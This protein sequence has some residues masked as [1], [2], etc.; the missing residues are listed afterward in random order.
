MSKRKY[1]NCMYF[2]FDPHTILSICDGFRNNI[3]VQLISQHPFGVTDIYSRTPLIRRLVIRTGFALRVNLSITLK[4][5]ASL[6]FTGY[7][8]K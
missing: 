4:K 6:E 5:L 3:H 7:R 1:E 2:C 8:I